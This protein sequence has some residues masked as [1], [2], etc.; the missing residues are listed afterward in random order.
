MIQIASIE[1][2]EVL[3]KA[4]TKLRD[5]TRRR[6]EHPFTNCTN[7]GLVTASFRMFLTTANESPWLRFRF[8]KSASAS[9]KTPWKGVSTRN[10]IK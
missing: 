6:F 8:V 10:S 5:P 7:C 2:I 3:P 9:M 1:R 4:D